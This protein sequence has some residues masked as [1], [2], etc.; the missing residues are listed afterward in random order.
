MYRSGLSLGA[1]LIAAC[2]PPPDA[3]LIARHTDVWALWPQ[4]HDAAALRDQLA[5]TYTG[6]ALTDQ[7]VS[8]HR[9]RHQLDAS[10][11]RLRVYDATL[12]EQ[13]PAGR[14]TYVT[15]E[16]TLDLA[17]DGHEHHR[18]LRLGHRLRVVATPEGPRIA[19]ITPTHTVDL[20]PTDLD[21]TLP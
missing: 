17:H 7:L 21:T 16:I 10:G 4:A 9:A 2:A 3:G 19:A 6:G 11:G 18:R 12:I 5:L 8:L 14:D 1:L 15:S 20:P 13:Q